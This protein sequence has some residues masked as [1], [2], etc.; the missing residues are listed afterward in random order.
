M[1][2]QDSAAQG[3][4]R[5]SERGFTM[6]EI[7]TVIFIILVISAMAITQMQPALETYRANAAEAQVKGAL[8]QARETAVAERRNIVV[9]FLLNAQGQEE[10]DLYQVPEPANIV[11][12]APFMK[13]PVQ[14]TVFF[15]LYPGAP[16]TPDNF[17][18]GAPLFFGGAAYLPGSNVQF[19]SDGT[20]ADAN[21]NPI[22]GSIFM[23][24][25]GYAPSSRAITIL[26]TTGRIKS[27]TGT[28]KAW[29][30]Q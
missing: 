26:G 20:F 8:R 19:Q 5:N 7:V 23:S 16:D 9:R 2:K 10:V 11:A 12:N 27:W 29:F 13:V 6:V 3:R 15:A 17:G 4:H 25:A 22:N 18:K 24:I 30:Q 1:S 14:G 28:G 21:G